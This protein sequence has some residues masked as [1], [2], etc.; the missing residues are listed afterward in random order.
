M[1]SYYDSN[2]RT[3]AN[4]VDLLLGQEVAPHFPTEGLYLGNLTGGGFEMPALFDLSESKG[5]C[6]LYRNEQ[7]RQQA[8]HCLERLVWRLALTLPSNLCDLVLYNGGNPGDAFSTHQ[9]INNYLFDNRKERVYFDGTSAEFMTLLNE[10][11]ASIVDRMS[12]IRCAGKQTLAELNETLGHE[13][14]LKFQF[15]F[16]TDFPRHIKTEMAQRLSQIVEAGAKAGIYVLMSW[17]MTADFEDAAHSSISFSAEQMMG[18]MELL[19]P[20]GSGFCFRNSGHDDVFN[21]F[22]YEVDAQP[23]DAMVVEK[24]VQQVDI[25]VETARKQAKPATLKQDFRRLEETAYE[26]VMSEISITVGLD[27]RDKHSVTVRFNSRDY[28]HAFVLGQSGSGKSVLINNIITSAILKYSPQDL[29]LYL[30]DF[31]GVEFDK[32]RGVKHTKAV[33][34]DNS[35]PQMTLEVLRELKEENKRRVKLCQKKAVSNIDGYN[36]MF[37]DSR[38]P[39]ILFVADECQVMFR[40]AT[41]S[42]EIAIQREI[43]EILD[44]IATQ[45]RSQG[46]H[47][48][49]ATQQLDETDI[50]GQILKNLTECFLLMSAPSDSERL[51]PDSSD[52]TSKQMTGL[53]C[54]YHKKELQSQVQTY[55]ATNEELKLAISA[56]QTKAADL[57]GNGEHFFSGSSIYTLDDKEKQLIRS[58]EER[59]PTAYVGHDIGMKGELTAL[60]LARDFSE[61]VLLTGINKEGQAVGVAVSA[62]ESFILSSQRHGQPFDVKVIDCYNDPQAR[63]RDRLEVLQG[64][65]LCQ[66]VERTESGDVLR[67]LAND[68]HR[69]SAMPTLLVILGSERYAE[70]KRNVTLRRGDTKSASSGFD[71]STG[72]IN[73][74]FFCDDNGDT[75]AYAEQ[76]EAEANKYATDEAE[77]ESVVNTYPEALRYILDNGPMQDVHVVLQ[78]DKATNILFEDYPDQTVSLFKHKVLLRSENKY[79]TPMR[80]S[81]DIDVESLSEEEEHLRAY[82]YPEDGGPRLFTPYIICND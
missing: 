7:E 30:M 34:V 15:L 62:V 80:F 29:M 23:I 12:T 70:M 24:C 46:I 57:P 37:P 64:K 68:L 26:P 56:A 16:L 44:I 77:E 61:N 58:A 40:R 22:G 66:I 65:G 52:L 82:Y 3:V 63:Y 53:A 67:Q 49:L 81:I 54:Y 19:V 69:Q 42:T 38:L 14:R 79:L 5:L 75:S 21:R 35:D 47:M 41:G 4:S 9:R 45:G 13:T 43:A 20:T 27:V 48:L 33:L 10:V 73:M 8:N 55:Y 17:D 11:Y 74:D 25:L 2:P 50:S 76:I 1:K 36:R 71:I 78:A 18:N 31:K 28:I 32:Y 51:V 72:I 6:F 60:P 39:Q 59:Y